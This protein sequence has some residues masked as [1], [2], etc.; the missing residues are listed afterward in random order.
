MLIQIPGNLIQNIPVLLQQAD[1]LIITVL[2]NLHD[3]LIYLR[4]RLFPTIETGP[5]IKIFILNCYK[6]HQSEPVGHTILC[7]HRPC[8]LSCLLNIIGGSGR[9]RIKYDFFCGTPSHIGDKPRSQLV[10]GHQILLFFRHLHGITQRPH[11]TRHNRNLLYRLCIFLQRGNQRMAYLMVCNHLL[12]FGTHDAVLF[13]FSCNNHF[14]RF[15]EISLIHTLPA[16]F[17]RID[18]SLIN[19]IGKV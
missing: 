1:S 4:C 9:H 16:A 3:F 15:K 5:A 6:S 13:L 17:H 8:N 12:L 11:G 14:H 2:Q 7:H 18:G 19:H 10:F